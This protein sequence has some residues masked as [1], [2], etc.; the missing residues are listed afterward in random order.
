[1]DI[2]ELRMLMVKVSQRRHDERMN[3]YIN[4]ANRQNNNKIQMIEEDCKSKAS[5]ALHQKVWKPG[6]LRMKNT[7]QH[8][9][10]DDQMQHKFWD[11]GIL[12]MEGYDQ[13]VIFLSSWGV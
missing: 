8:D 4:R 7:K 13:E 9:E 10:M 6:E 2:K 3:I 11:P 1:M 5:G 12:N